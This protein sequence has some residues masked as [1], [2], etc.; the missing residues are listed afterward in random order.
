ML[1]ML[2]NVVSS[3]SG[4]EIY[5]I[6]SILLFFVVF[7]GT[8]VW[9]AVLKKSFLNSLSVLPLDD[10]DSVSETKEESHE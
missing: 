9:S 10:G 4:V 8:M 1:T 3:M 6:V 7:I 2:R 5:G